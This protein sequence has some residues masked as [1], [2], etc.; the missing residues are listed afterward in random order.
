MARRQ[1]T[2]KTIDQIHMEAEME[3][4]QEK[5]MIRS[6]QPIS[7]KQFTKEEKRRGEPTICQY[8]C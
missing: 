4:I 8:S 2:L 3:A 7:S 1:E 5:E 6:L